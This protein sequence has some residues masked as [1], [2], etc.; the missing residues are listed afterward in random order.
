MSL[1]LVFVLPHFLHVLQ[2]FLCF[3]F[4]FLFLT[5][6]ELF[7]I[8]QNFCIYEPYGGLNLEPLFFCKDQ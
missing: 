4:S 7:L 1:Y 6:Q 3:L 8:W 5:T 2:M